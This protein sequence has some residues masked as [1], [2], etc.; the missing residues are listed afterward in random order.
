MR[1]DFTDDQEELRSGVRGVLG[2]ECTMESVRAL[3]ETGRPLDSLWRQMVDLGWPALTV[4]ESAGGLGLGF[5]ECA[6]VAEELGRVVAP[7]PWLPTVTQFVPVVRETGSPEQ[8]HDLLAEV[9]AGE[10]TGT[11]ALAEETG[12]FDVADVTAEVAPDGD[13]W[14]LSGT[15]HWIVEGD[16]VDTLAVIARLPGTRGDE[17]VTSV[18]VDTAV[19]EISPLETFDATRSVVTATFDGVHLGAGAVLGE[20]GGDAVPVRRAV[21]EATVALS[22]EMV[23]TAQTIFDTVLAYAKDRHQFGVPIGSFQ[24]IKHKFAD[25]YV[26]LERA[27]SVAYLA[28]ATI[29]DDDER[30]GVTASMAKVAAGDAQKR[31]AKEGIQVLGGIG[32]TWEHDMHLLVRRLKSGDALFGTPADHRTRVA[33]LAADEPGS[34]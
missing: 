31:I 14:A 22:L 15:K 34:G 4:P 17:G 13:G 9:A 1:L 20:P 7:G 29:A 16:H 11:L 28:T 25:M 21:E 8:R 24:A 5:V 2:A 12:S 10:R 6:V 27:R 32:Y 26:L 33:A 18:I 30:R 23:G 3:A 19:A